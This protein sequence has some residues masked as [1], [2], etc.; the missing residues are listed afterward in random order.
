[1]ET[2]LSYLENMFMNLPKTAEV[3]RAK[4]ELASMMEDKYSELLAEGKRENEAVG[5][6]ISEFGNLEELAEELGIL[7]TVEM[8]PEESAGRKVSWK[9]AEEYME[10]SQ[11]TGKWIALG[12]LLCIYSPLLLLICGGIEDTIGLSEFYI[13]CFGL[14]PLFVMIGIAVAIFI[15]NGMKRERFEYL[16]KEQICLVDGLEQDL[17]RIKEEEKSKEIKMVIVGILL[18]I[19]SIIPLFIFG[20][21]SDNDLIGAMVIDLMLILIGIGV[22]LMII[23]TQKSECMKVLLQEDDYTKKGKENSKL[24]DIIAGIYWPIVTAVYLIWSFVTMNWGFT[25]IVWPI[26]AVLFGVIAAI[27]AVISQGMNRQLQ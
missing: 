1:M 4:E 18:C 27:C 20:S 15:Y 12:V 8:M 2:I 13:V 26:A 21:I 17:R 5:I 9:E 19:F 25:W 11:K 3:L 24:I 10:I 14:I 23:G 22:M 16:K 6:V 7:G